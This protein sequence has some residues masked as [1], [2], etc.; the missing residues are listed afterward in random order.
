MGFFDSLFTRD[1]EDAETA[2]PSEQLEP[3]MDSA[4][5]S[6]LLFQGTVG[7]EE[8]MGIPAFA[9]CVDVISSTVAALPVRLYRR[10]GGKVEEVRDDRRV[11]LL[12]GETVIGSGTANLSAATDYTEFTVPVA[13]SV[14][15]QKATS[16]RIMITSSN[17]A[18]Y[19]QSTETATI[20]TTVYNGQYEAASRGATLTIE[21]LTFNFV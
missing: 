11:R 18:S 10:V 6:A 19:T 20:K 14:T 5:L 8:A 12:N 2:A 17:H 21:K 9:A 15:N 16:L 4:L 3:Q 1:A 7:K 13:Y